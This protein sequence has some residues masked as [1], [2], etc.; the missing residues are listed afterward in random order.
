MLRFTTVVVAA[1]IGVILSGVVDDAPPSFAHET[2]EVG[3]YVFEVGWAI[4]PTAVEAP[5]SL[6]LVIEDKDSGEGVSD[7]EE[8]LEAEIITGGGAQTK[9][10]PLEPSGEEPGIYGSPVIPT[11]AGDYTFRISGT[12]EGQTIDESF[13]SGPE[14]FDS[15]EDVTKLQFPGQVPSNADL[16]TSLD[17]LSDQ[18]AGLDSGGDSDTATILAIIGIIVGAVGIGVGG[19]ALAARRS[20]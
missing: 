20:M 19:F 16:Q 6:F 10:L 11:Q 7:L 12:I 15:V 8:T 18:I 1:I 17:G 13:S 14:T 4:E 2:R 3:D 5:N 9:P